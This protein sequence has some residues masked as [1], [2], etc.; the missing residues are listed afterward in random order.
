[1]HPDKGGDPEMVKIKF[2][3]IILPVPLNII[4]L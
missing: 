3:I 4:C 2:E 1:M